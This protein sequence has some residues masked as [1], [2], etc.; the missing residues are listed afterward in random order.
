MIG[1]SKSHDY[2]YLIKMPNLSV[3]LLCFSKF[4]LWHL[5]NKHFLERKKLFLSKPLTE[6][7]TGHCF[8]SIIFGSPKGKRAK[9][10]LNWLLLSTVTVVV[11]VVAV[12]VVVVIV[13][14]IVI[15][16]LAK[17]IL[18][19]WLLCRVNLKLIFARSHLAH[20]FLPEY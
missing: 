10:N 2:S 8:I 9:Q 19:T 11:I 13:V 17:T 1:C 7:K 12:V 6:V 18:T 20:I 5:G 4:C 15:V 3:T 16:Q 14:G